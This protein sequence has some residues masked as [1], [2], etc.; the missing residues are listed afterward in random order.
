MNIEKQ[1]FQVREEILEN[2]LQ[3]IS[4]QK[5]ANIASLHVGMDIGAM[6]EGVGEKGICHFIEH[7]LFK[8][9]EKRDNHMI[10]QALEERAG[11]YDAYTD[12]TST[13]FSITA[14]A[15]E[16]E[17]SV[18]I[19]SDM[20]MHAT[21]PSHEIEKEKKVILAEVKACKDDIEQYTYKKINELAFRQSPLR[22]DVIGD[23]KIIKAF[24]K[25][26]LEAFYHRHYIPN[27]C[28]ISVVSPYTHH[29][30]VRM[31]EKYFGKWE[32]GMVSDREIMI[33]KN[34]PIQKTSYKSNIEQN[35][36]IYLYTF[37]GLSRKEELAL[38]ILN[39]K[40]GVSANSIL[41]RVLREDSGIAYDVYSEMDATE[42]IK[43]LYI[44]A[45][46]SKE[47]LVL[48]KNKIENCIEDLKTKRGMISE[49]D[50]AL[51]KKV[52]KTGVASMLEDSTAL[53][54]YVLHQKISKK[55]IYEFIE[56]MKHLE[57]IQEKDIF[58]VAQKVLDEP[59]IHILTRKNKKTKDA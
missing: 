6:Y 33:E 35:T 14:L 50:I 52:I 45:A 11:A 57:Y 8:G 49:K 34:H 46:V 23:E 26:Q 4:I 15:N 24:T 43:T 39:H 17:A 10:N 47:D 40:L 19:L 2:G 18:E 25:S 38:E 13:V 36:L 44:Y 12:Y 9:T 22:Y 20:M 59:T 55:N 32:K 21:F 5:D 48:A 29:E 28:V 42:A 56:D 53:G 41:F 31:I 16:L 37:H 51:M 3:I 27:Q 54:N 7:M 1:M 58:E 30:V